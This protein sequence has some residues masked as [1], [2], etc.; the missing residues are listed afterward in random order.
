MSVKLVTTSQICLSLQ[1]GHIIL[2][3][4]CHEI[5]PK[6]IRYCTFKRVYC[7]LSDCV[8]MHRTARVPGQIVNLEIFFIQSPTLE[9]ERRQTFLVFC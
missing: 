1:S 4:G 7:L 3:Q 2:I 6:T 8:Y 9:A 5:I